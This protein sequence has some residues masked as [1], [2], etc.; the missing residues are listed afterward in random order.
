MTIGERVF[1]LMKEQRRTQRDLANYL[2]V[3][4]TTVSYWARNTQGMFPSDMLVPVAGYLGVSVYYLLTG[5]DDP[6]PPVIN[7][8]SPDPESALPE[9][10]RELLKVFRGLDREGKV[11]TLS[12]AYTHRSRLAGMQGSEANIS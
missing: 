7:V 4:E 8:T 11:M 5:E 10:E 12:T 6:L 9:E 2:G 1:S 3:S